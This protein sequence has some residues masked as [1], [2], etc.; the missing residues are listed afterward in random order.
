ME[1]EIILKI[2]GAI[3]AVSSTGKIFYDVTTGRKSRLREDYKFAKEFLEDI[4]NN[5]DL[6]PFAVEKGYHAIAG[7]V[8]L[9]S[10]E[11]A[12]LL[13]LKNPGKCLND[14]VLS[15]KYL[16]A[17]NIDGDFRLEFSKKYSSLL[18]RRIRKIFYISLYAI[19]GIIALAPIF[20]PSKFAILFFITLPGF[21]YYALFFLNL[22]IQIYR[23]EQ[24]VNNQKRHTQ[25]ILLPTG[26]FPS[27]K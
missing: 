23:G 18:S 5:P 21:G 9:K 19:F 20:A 25:K 7:S 15:R 11:V 8:A 4:K 1:F 17:I 13:S 22:Y 24:L 14:Y 27:L 26:N 3:V 6:H 16:R 12:Y 2:I 10:E